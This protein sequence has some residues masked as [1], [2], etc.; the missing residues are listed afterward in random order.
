MPTLG[1]TFC[2][3]HSFCTL[4]LFSDDKMLVE[5][6]LRTH[7]PH[8]HYPMKDK[9]YSRSVVMIPHSPPCSSCE[10]FTAL[11]METPPFMANA[12]KLP[13]EAASVIAGLR[14]GHVRFCGSKAP[15]KT[16]VV[17]TSHLHLD[18][19]LQVVTVIICQWLQEWMECRETERREANGERRIDRIWVETERNDA[20]QDAAGELEQQETSDGFAFFCL[21]RFLSPTAM[22]L[23][24][25]IER[26]E[27]QIPLKEAE[28]ITL[29]WVWLLERAVIHL[30]SLFLNI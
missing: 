15:H 8:T 29:H 3:L 16:T 5:A 24:S 12:S 2:V 21:S 7:Y 23:V 10:C 14:R 25:P 30:S 28:N 11:M 19:D 17:I 22:T 20:K 18:Y 6:W 27:L 13:E 4:L 9:L 1:Y 26:K